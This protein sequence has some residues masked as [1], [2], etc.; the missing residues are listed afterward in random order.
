MATTNFDIRFSHSKHLKHLQIAWLMCP[1]A[2]YFDSRMN[3]LGG[4]NVGK[5]SSINQK[6]VAWEV[7]GWGHV[8]TNDQWPCSPHTK[9]Y[10][11]L[12]SKWWSLFILHNVTKNKNDHEWACQKMNEKNDMKITWDHIYAYMNNVWWSHGFYNKRVRMICLS[13]AIRRPYKMKKNSMFSKVV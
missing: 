13:G 12:R 11:W 7:K 8:Y 5:K 6:W 3:P 2:W 9:I 1:W 4:I 10:H